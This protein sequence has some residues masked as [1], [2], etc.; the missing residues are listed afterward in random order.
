MCFQEQIETSNDSVASSAPVTQQPESSTTHHAALEDEGAE[1]EVTVE[2]PPPMQEI[3]TIPLP[4][5]DVAADEK[6]VS[7]LSCFWQES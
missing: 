2:M 4:S 3:S 5:N 7:V 6:L 1:E